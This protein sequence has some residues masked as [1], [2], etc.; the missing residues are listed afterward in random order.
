MSAPP[1][2]IA[3]RVMAMDRDEFEAVVVAES[4]GDCGADITAALS[5]GIDIAERW[6][7]Q[8]RR[9]VKRNRRA[10]DHPSVRAKRGEDWVVR[11]ETFVGYMESRLCEV[12]PVVARLR[13]DHEHTHLCQ[14]LVEAFKAL[15]DCDGEHDVD[16]LEA[17]W[18]IVDRLVEA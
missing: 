16:L 15:D 11:T 7:G 6:Q 17:Q 3:E 8:L 10:L 5:S 9:L 14:I 18:R 1:T 2:D 12:E 4:K 13:R